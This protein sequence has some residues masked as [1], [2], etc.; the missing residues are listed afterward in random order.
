MPGRTEDRM[1][2]LRPWQR[3]K[4][5]YYNYNKKEENEKDDNEKDEK[6]DKKDDDE[7]PW[8]Y[9]SIE[10][11]VK[12]ERPQTATSF[13]RISLLRLCRPP[14]SPI[15]HPPNSGNINTART[16]DTGPIMSYRSG[17]SQDAQPEDVDFIPGG[18]YVPPHTMLQQNSQQVLQVA[19]QQLTRFPN[20]HLYYGWGA[21]YDPTTDV[22][23]LVDYR[24]YP[25]RARAPATTPATATA[26]ATA[27]VTAAAM[28]QAT[29]PKPAPEQA[30]ATTDG[31]PKK[32]NKKKPKKKKKATSNQ[33]PT[34]EGSK[35][36]S[37]EVH[38][39][40][41]LTTIV[42]KPSL[43][44]AQDDLVGEVVKEGK[45]V[46]G[47]EPAEDV[48][49]AQDVEPADNAKSVDECPPSKPDAPVQKA[50][51]STVEN[52]LYTRPARGAKIKPGYSMDDLTK[53]EILT[54]VT[55]KEATGRDPI[56]DVPWTAVD[57][58]ELKELGYAWIIS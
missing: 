25:K 21:A 45:P 4:E 13:S 3:N 1:L 10:Y 29:I 53:K 42:E 37:D 15:L 39:S 58:E 22:E 8:V 17:P 11:S 7:V 44:L 36:G 38:T 51:I 54:A 9:S 43:L 23:K 46:E 19:P 14:P 34:N 24:Y 28:D 12:Q 6:D 49:P 56:R 18:T 31:A 33:A 40:E 35:Q 47:V 55:W 16:P 5:D 27:T 30:S 2:E 57:W 52:P 50:P 48:E 41:A 26:P 32:K 20:T